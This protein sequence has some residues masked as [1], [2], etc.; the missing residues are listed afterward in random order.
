MITWSICILVAASLVLLAAWWFS[1]IAERHARVALA[2]LRDTKTAIAQWWD[3][4]EDGR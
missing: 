2:A 1:R 4:K 3:R